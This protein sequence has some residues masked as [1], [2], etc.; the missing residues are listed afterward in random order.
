MA[1]FQHF[2]PEN[3]IE[4]RLTIRYFRDVRYFYYTKL[5]LNV[6]VA[7]QKYLAIFA[8]YRDM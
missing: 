6:V 5:F 3:D 7:Y 8:G 2:V 4:R 1:M